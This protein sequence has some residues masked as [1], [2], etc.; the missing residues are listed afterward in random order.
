MLC[1]SSGLVVIERVA[2]ERRG[3]AH[4]KVQLPSRRPAPRLAHA[5]HCAVL[6]DAHPRPQHLARVVVNAAAHIQQQVAFRACCERIA[7]H[8]HAFCG[9]QLRPHLCVLQG[10]GVVARLGAF[11]RVRE[12]RAIAWLRPLHIARLQRHIL[13]AHRHHHHV[14]QVAVPRAGKMRVREALNRSV[15]VP[16]AGRPLVALLEGANLGVGRKLHHA[17]RRCRS[18]KGVAVRPGADH[19]IH[20]LERFL[21][22]CKRNRAGQQNSK[23]KALLHPTKIQYLPLLPSFP[24]RLSPAS[25]LCR[26]SHDV[27]TPR[28]IASAS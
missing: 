10:H 28:V 16:V 11:A 18:R 5:G 3:E 12:A 1:V 8:A 23:T 21:S 9:G 4:G 2:G 24:E 6:A 14:A 15:F 27:H 20:Q 7:M 19:R 13:A 22:L 25:N 26:Q 17:E